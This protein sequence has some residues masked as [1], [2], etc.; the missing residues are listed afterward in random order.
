MNTILAIA[1]GG[2]VGAV[3]RHYA[4]LLFTF[5]FGTLFVNILGSFIMGV[6]IEALALKFNLSLEMRAFLATG[7]LGAFTTFSTF[8]LDVLKLVDTNQYFHAI[9]YVFASVLL[10][11]TAIFIAV[12]MT[13]GIL[14]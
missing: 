3:I 8:S 4:M 9:S 11:I 5:P 7:F 10:S 14:G 6:L 1:L 2:S 12:Y 13:R